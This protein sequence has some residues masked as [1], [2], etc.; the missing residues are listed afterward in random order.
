MWVLA[1]RKEENA[2]KIANDTLKSKRNINIHSTNNYATITVSQ[3]LIGSA[4]VG[5]SSS[6]VCDSDKSMASQNQYAY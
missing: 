5:A 6:I 2:Y 3:T 1:K 4:V